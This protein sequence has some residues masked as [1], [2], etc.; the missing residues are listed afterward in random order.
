MKQDEETAQRAQRRVP[1]SP[2]AR[3][4][5]QAVLPCVLVAAAAKEGCALA[6]FDSLPEVFFGE[7]SAAALIISR[8]I[9]RDGALCRWMSH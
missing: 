9:S 8:I 4:Q 1:L 5:P 6:Y 3:G 7:R 2:L